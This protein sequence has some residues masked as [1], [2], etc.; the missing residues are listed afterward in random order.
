MFAEDHY[1]RRR[2]PLECGG[3]TPPFQRKLIV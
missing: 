3:L 1:M 2:S